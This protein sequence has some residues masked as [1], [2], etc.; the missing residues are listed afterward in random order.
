MPRA[1]LAALVVAA[2]TAA[3]GPAAA[4]S[5]GPVLLH[6]AGSLRSVLTEIVQDFERDTGIKVA[7]TFGPS[8]VL[9][10]RIAAGTPAHVFASANMEHPRALAAAGRAAAPE[11]F[12]R[13]S[14]CVLA[15]PGAVDGPAAVLE[16]ML[17]SERRLATST[18]GSDPSGDYAFEAFAKA[19]RIRPG[20]QRMLESKALKLVG[21]ADSPQPP[22]GRS[23]YAWH[24]AEQRADLFV[25]YCTNAVAAR[26]EMPTLAQ[27]PLP[28]AMSVHAEYGMA[29]LEGAP[30]EAGR[31]F[32]HILSPAGQRRLA[33]HGFAAVR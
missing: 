15:R 5:G 11:P 19:E 9:R 22:G 4:Q 31:L 28:E 20:A 13:N 25:T 10:D 1:I 2:G 14:L 16:A 6:A 27:Y 17:S 30:P 8:G 24:I 7:A 29:L 21:A 32:A 33:A 26:A 12:T 3:A 23:A 18:P